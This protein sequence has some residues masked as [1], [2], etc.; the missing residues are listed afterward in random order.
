[1][2]RMAPGDLEFLITQYLDGR[3]PERERLELERKLSQDPAAAR[4]MKEQR[5]LDGILSLAA[6]LPPIDWD[7]LALRISAAVAMQAQPVQRHKRPRAWVGATVALAACLL[8]VVGISLL[9]RRGPV[10]PS[11]T[12]GVDADAAIVVGPQA[13]EA[14]GQPTIAEVTLA[15]A[16]LPATAADEDAARPSHVYITSAILH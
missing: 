15:S 14:R 3:L 13:E 6:P 4:L 16:S 2:N 8:V 10:P 1:L 7:A 12:V 9:M 5:E 11:H